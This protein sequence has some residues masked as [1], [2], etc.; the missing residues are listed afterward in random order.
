M[1]SHPPQG[2]QAVTGDIDRR[3]RMTVDR[4]WYVPECGHFTPFLVS[5]EEATETGKGYICPRCQEL[6]IQSLGRY[7]CSGYPTFAGM[8]TIKKD[9]AQ[10]D[11]DG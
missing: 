3:E 9:Q 2:W 10:K 8:T 4:C 11:A 1:V 7:V 5:D 6:G